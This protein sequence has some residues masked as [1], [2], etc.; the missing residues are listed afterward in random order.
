MLNYITCQQQHKSFKLPNT[1]MTTSEVDEN[2]DPGLR[3]T[4]KCGRVKL[5][6]EI[7]TR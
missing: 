4:Q 3:Q 7:Q 2:L 5:V 6:N 1:E